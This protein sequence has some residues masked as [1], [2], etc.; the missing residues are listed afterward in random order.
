[1]EPHQR[2]VRP[3]SRSPATPITSAISRHGGGLANE[4]TRQR[5]PRPTWQPSRR[6]CPSSEKRPGS[7]RSEKLQAPRVR[8]WMGRRPRPAEELL[9]TIPH[10]GFNLALCFQSEPVLGIT[11]HPLLG[12][13]YLAVK[14]EGCTCNG[15]SVT[16]SG[17]RARRRRGRHRYGLRRGTRASNRPRELYGACRACVYASSAALGFA[18][19]A[20]ARW[21][22]YVHWTCSRGRA[23]ASLVRSR[24][25]PEPATIYL[26]RRSRRTLNARG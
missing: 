3:R 13:T 21:D 4:G 15:Q 22:I 25:R 9:R 6:S 12:D 1:M 2:L 17:A 14:G 8:G 10:F 24:D 16:V 5:E 19:V 7:P 26:A 18:Y 11:T 23:G 20:S